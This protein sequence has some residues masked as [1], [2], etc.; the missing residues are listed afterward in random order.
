MTFME[1]LVSVRHRPRH[2]SY[3]APSAFRLRDTEGKGSGPGDLGTPG[4]PSV[5]SAEQA[6]CQCLRRT[7]SKEFSEYSGQPLEEVLLLHI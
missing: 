4:S 7:V 1:P 6:P 5:P 3:V 2:V